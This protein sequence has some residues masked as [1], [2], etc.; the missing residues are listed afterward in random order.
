MINGFNPVAW[1]ENRLREMRN[2]NISIAAE[3]GNA[4]DKFSW[5]I[6]YNNDFL[7]K[8][9]RINGSLADGRVKIRKVTNGVDGKIRLSTEI[10][11]LFPLALKKFEIDDDKKPMVYVIPDILCSSSASE[12]HHQYLTFST[13][14]T[15]RM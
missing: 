11:Q 12:L 13:E 10:Q 9:L 2:A 14:Y 8:E 15:T 3:S 1:A 7:Y 5:D 6:G 4:A